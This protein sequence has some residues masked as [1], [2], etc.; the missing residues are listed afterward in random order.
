[1]DH[2]DDYEV[3]ERDNFEEENQE[4]EGIDLLEDHPPHSKRQKGEEQNYYP[5]PDFVRPGFQVT[6]NTSYYNLSSLY[7]LL[8]AHVKEGVPIPALFL[9]NTKGF[10][11]N[12]VEY[13]F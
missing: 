11:S 10:E 7:V 1:M 12:N 2:E 3:E 9:V 8:Y 6:D 13:D 4:D 5:P